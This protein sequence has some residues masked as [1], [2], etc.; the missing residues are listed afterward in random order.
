MDFNTA[1][2]RKWSIKLLMTRS[3][4]SHTV[5]TLKALSNFIKAEK[6]RLDENDELR[7]PLVP[8][9]PWV[10][11]MAFQDFTRAFSSLGVDL[12]SMDVKE[13]K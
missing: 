7:R 11:E 1:R 4:E 6:K 8:L 12:I 2:R 3:L 5:V 10:I 9:M 13:W